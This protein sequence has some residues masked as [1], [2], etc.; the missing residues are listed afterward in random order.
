MDLHDW[1]DAVPGRATATAEHFGVSVSAVS[2][3]RGRGAPVRF[4]RLISKWTEGAVSVD[5]L[6]ALSESRRTQQE[7]A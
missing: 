3:W 6:L 2:Q 1:I 5:E 7:A 4:W